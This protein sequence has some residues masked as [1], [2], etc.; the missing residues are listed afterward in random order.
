[1]LVRVPRRSRAGAVRGAAAKAALFPFAAA[2]TPGRGAVGGA[3]GAL[4]RLLML[5]GA[6]VSRRRPPRRCAARGGGDADVDC[7]SARRSVGVAGQRE[8][9][10]LCELPVSKRVL[11][12]HIVEAPCQLCL[13][14]SE[15]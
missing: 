14:G 3:A 2:A 4:L 13:W 9:E 7:R 8:R 1:M 15:R 5:H 11:R 10:L 6:H 12:G